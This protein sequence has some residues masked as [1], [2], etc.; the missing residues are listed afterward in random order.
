MKMNAQ[1]TKL[2]AAEND[3]KQLMPATSAV[4]PLTSSLAVTVPL[5][6]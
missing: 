4:T 6:S 5:K 2:Q 3:L 1:E